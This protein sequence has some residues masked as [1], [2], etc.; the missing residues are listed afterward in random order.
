MPTGPSLYDMLLGH[1]ESEP[2]EAHDDKT[3]EILSVQANT[4]RDA[5]AP[6]VLHVPGLQ[7]KICSTCSWLHLLKSWSLHQIRGGSASNASPRRITPRY[8]DGGPSE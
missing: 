1:I 2:L 8:R 4:R 3:L 5:L 7:Q 6:S